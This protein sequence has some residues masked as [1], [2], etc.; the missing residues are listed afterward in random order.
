MQEEKE[1]YMT[2]KDEMKKKWKIERKIITKLK[3]KTKIFS[4]SYMKRKG[5]KEEKKERGER[6]NIL[7]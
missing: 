6:K 5:R 3:N 2:K 4:F 7:Q 1:K